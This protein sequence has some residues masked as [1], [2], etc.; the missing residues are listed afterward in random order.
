MQDEP[1]T[2]KDS[3]TKTDEVPVAAGEF[4]GPAVAWED[5]QNE[6]KVAKNRQLVSFLE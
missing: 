6:F 5:D 4:V 2:E 3:T 1:K